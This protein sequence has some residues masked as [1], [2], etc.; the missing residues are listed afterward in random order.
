MYMG[1][2]FKNQLAAIVDSSD[3]AIISAT[4]EGIITIWNAGAERLM[5]YTADE[6]IGRPVG[7]LIPP[8]RQEE[9]CK[10]F[11]QVRQGQRVDHFETERLRK[12]GGRVPISL[13]AV[14]IRDG[15]GRITGISEIARDVSERNYMEEQL[16]QRTAQLQAMDRHKDEFLAMLAHELRNP[17][18]PIKNAVS[19]LRTKGLSDATILQWAQEIIDRQVEH[20]SHLVDD[21]L[22]ASRIKHGKIVLQK[23]ST[24]LGGL[25][26][27]AEK[28]SAPLIEARNQRLITLPPPPGIYVNV[29]EARLIQV[30]S[31]L[32]DNAAKYSQEGSRIWLTTEL[33]DP[34]VIIRVRDEGI[35]IPMELLPRIFDLF[36]QGDR[37]LD[38]SQGGLG[39][40]LSLVKSLIEMHG[41]RVEAF[42][43]GIGHGSEFTVRLPVLARPGEPPVSDTRATPWP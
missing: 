16:R 38:R 31:N 32:L 42:S 23:Q 29:D 4:P 36:V 27:L 13:T 33:Q 37:T 30:L 1:V 35:G 17:L 15:Q 9:E 18:A 3:D 2:T 14:P 7:I 21:L 11:E 20:L 12:D 19:I 43:R 22:D 6:A 40:G 24:D 28:A 10:I 34:E 8:E 39:V 5:G 41:G 26:L 25:I